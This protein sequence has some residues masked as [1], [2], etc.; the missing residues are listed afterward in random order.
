ML[1]YALEKDLLEE[2]DVASYTKIISSHLSKQTQLLIRSFLLSRHFSSWHVNKTT[3]ADFK[4][5]K[6]QCTQRT[7]ACSR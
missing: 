5:R 3:T 7:N 2:A 1:N 4:T 6:K